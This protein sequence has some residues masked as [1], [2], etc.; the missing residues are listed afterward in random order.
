M[1]VDHPVYKVI[2][3]IQIYYIV[4]I[5]LHFKLH[6]KMCVLVITYIFSQ[7]NQENSAFTF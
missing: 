2:N 6:S 1:Y 3:K 5:F 4:Y 7:I